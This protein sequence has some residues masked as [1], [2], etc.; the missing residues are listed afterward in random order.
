MAS[1]A[2][3][4]HFLRQG[5]LWTC[6][7][8]PTGCFEQ[9]IHHAI[10]HENTQKHRTETTHYTDELH[11]AQTA[12]LNEPHLQTNPLLDAIFIASGLLLNVPHPAPLPCHQQPL[13]QDPRQQSPPGSFNDELDGGIDMEVDFGELNPP[14]PSMEDMHARVVSSVSVLLRHM[15]DHGFNPSAVDSDNGEGDVPEDEDEFVVN[16]NAEVSRRGH[17]QTQDAHEDAWYPWKNRLSCTLDIISN[18]PRGVFSQDELEVILWQLKQHGVHAVPSI[19]QIKSV[20]HAIDG[21]CGVE[22]NHYIGCLGHTY[23]MI[24]LEFIVKM[25]FANPLVQSVLEVYPEDSSPKLEEIRQARC[26]LE[27]HDARLLTPMYHVEG[28]IARDFYTD[29]P[30]LLKNGMLCMPFSEGL[31]WLIDQHDELSLSTNDLSMTF[32]ELEYVPL[33]HGR[34]T[35]Q[36][37]FSPP[38]EMLEGIVEQLES[39][40]ETGIWAYDCSYHDIIL[41]IISVLALLGD[42]PMQSE[43]A[44]HAGLM[45]KFFCRCCW[46]KGKDVADMLEVGGVKKETVQGML[47]GMVS[48]VMLENASTLARQKENVDLQTSTGVK[49]TIL[50]FF[51]DKLEKARKSLSGHAAR[52]ATQEAYS[53]LPANTFSPVWRIRGLNLHSDTPIEILHVVLL[54][55]LKYFW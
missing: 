17:N 46:V 14:P 49:D 25:A 43:F 15:V 9:D 33:G 26:W 16:V 8:C 24:S 42:N 38:L 12:A 29:E 7:C 13:G 20:G 19:H 50:C 36:S 37:T 55:F 28:R 32:P 23:Y 6:L 54:G 10:R 39:C 1:L 18:L 4:E 48:N 30:T 41:V 40:Q 27:E 5:N 11:A 35:L 34:P 53:R 3:P 2:Y 44:C 51:L 21:L 22:I 45:S 31:S 47:R 52:Q